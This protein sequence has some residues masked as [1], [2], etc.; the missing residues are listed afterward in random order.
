M[1][2]K[3]SNSMSNYCFPLKDSPLSSSSLSREGPLLPRTQGSGPGLREA[4]GALTL[5]L[6][7]PPGPRYESGTLG[8]GG[9]VG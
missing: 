4:F 8:P 6:P 5:Y 1:R 3:D 2:G 7:V 9:E